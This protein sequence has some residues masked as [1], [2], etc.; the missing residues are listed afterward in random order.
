MYTTSEAGPYSFLWKFYSFTGHLGLTVLTQGRYKHM[1]CS[2]VCSR[3][4]GK[5]RLCGN[6]PAWTVADSHSTYWNFKVLH[7]CLPLIYRFFLSCDFILSLSGLCILFLVY[8]V[9]SYQTFI[10]HLSHVEAKWTL[11]K[12]EGKGQAD[13]TLHRGSF[14]HMAVSHKATNAQTPPPRTSVICLP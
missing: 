12:A 8:Y 6:S 11:L 10:T 2:Y 13:K 14:T 3:Q 4:S 1:W 5:F 7:I 9:S